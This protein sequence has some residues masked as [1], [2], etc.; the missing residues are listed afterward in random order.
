[1]EEARKPGVKW[2]QATDRKIAAAQKEATDPT[3]NHQGD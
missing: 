2:K 1:M 3:Y